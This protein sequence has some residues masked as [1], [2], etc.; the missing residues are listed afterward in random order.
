MV[1]IGPGQMLGRSVR[2]IYRQAE[3]LS[4]DTAVAL[5]NTVKSLQE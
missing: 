2:W 4:T 1:E 5:E 3:V